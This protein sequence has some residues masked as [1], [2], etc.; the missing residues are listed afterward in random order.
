M[1]RN[2]LVQVLTLW[3]VVLIFIQTGSGA[4][5]NQIREAIG[6]F[7]VSLI[8]L[9]PLWIIIELASGFLAGEGLGE[10]DVQFAGAVSM[11]QI[12]SGSWARPVSTE[13]EF[14]ARDRE[15]ITITTKFVT[16]SDHE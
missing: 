5:D 3:F 9:L 7:A 13:E 6:I 10:K 12:T 15:I 1:E 8:L 16:Y 11:F 2:E 14:S 4:P